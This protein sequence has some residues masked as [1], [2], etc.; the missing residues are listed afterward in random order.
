MAL[1]LQ[2]RRRSHGKTLWLDFGTIE[3]YAACMGGPARRWCGAVSHERK[4]HVAGPLDERRFLAP[5]RPIDLI[6]AVQVQERE[7]H[8][9]ITTRIM[10]MENQLDK[11]ME[12]QCEEAKAHRNLADK[13]VQ[14]DGQHLEK[15]VGRRLGHLQ[16]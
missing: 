3:F 10:V 16:A 14:F 4:S 2:L 13:L 8:K 9:A 6:A 5:E 7:S 15:G 1:V 12:W 11:V